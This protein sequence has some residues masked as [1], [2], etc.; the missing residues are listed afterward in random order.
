MLFKASAATSKNSYT[1]IVHALPPNY[2]TSDP[3]PA[4]TIAGMRQSKIGTLT[5]LR[6]VAILPIA[7]V[8]DL[9]GLPAGKKQQK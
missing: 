6:S 9:Y 4:P 5:N 1:A 2:P 8:H 3:L 7:N